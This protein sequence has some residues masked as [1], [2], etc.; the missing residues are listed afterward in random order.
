MT[1][2]ILAHAATVQAI[3]DAGHQPDGSPLGDLDALREELDLDLAEVF[4]WQEAKSLAQ[5]QGVIS[6]DE[7]LTIYTAIGGDGGGGWTD[8]ASL[9]LRVSITSL[10]GQLLALK[11]RAA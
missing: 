5:A 7:A 9:A 8:D 10:I 11:G 2:R 6:G 4:A 1:N 3:I